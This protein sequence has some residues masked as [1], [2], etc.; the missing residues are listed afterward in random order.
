MLVPNRF[1]ELWGG[2]DRGETT[3]EAVMEEQ[4]RLL[5]DYLGLQTDVPSEKPVLD[6]RVYMLLRRGS[7]S[8]A[9]PTLSAAAGSYGGS[10]IARSSMRPRWRDET[11]RPN[12]A[13][14]ATMKAHYPLG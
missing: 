14:C 10:N 5:G 11:R 7:T 12:V 13:G 9:G 8:F 2:V 4:E 1:R 3:A 6:G